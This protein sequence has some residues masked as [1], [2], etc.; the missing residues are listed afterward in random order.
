MTHHVAGVVLDRRARAIA[1]SVSRIMQLR[2]GLRGA[3][4]GAARPFVDVECG[5]GRLA[6][7]VSA[8]TTRRALGVDASP[9]GRAAIPMVAGAGE[10]L[11][12]PDG[13]AAYV[14]LA[15]VLRR[16]TDPEATLREAL[17]VGR[18]GVFLIE[19]LVRRRGDRLLLGA[20]DAA[21]GS[22]RAPHYRTERQWWE[23][24]E[25]AGAQVTHWERL[26]DAYAPPASWLV[27]RD[28]HVV[29]VLEPLPK[30]AAPAA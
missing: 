9:A 2:D 18:H 5:D 3:A 26:R 20:L 27:G 6:A 14:M 29:M 8:R 4:E 19:L 28:L 11:P 30:P 23:M 21:S 22:G 13:A 24:A 25:R 7:S 17:R 12:F 10:R 1:A 15:D 16:A